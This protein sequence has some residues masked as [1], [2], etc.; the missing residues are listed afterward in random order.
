[1]EK[2][3]QVEIK[4][5]IMTGDSAGGALCMAITNWC[6]VNGIRGPDFI[7][8][9][10]PVANM[11]IKTWYTPSVMLAMDDAFLS[12]SMLKMCI[13]TY[14]PEDKREE[15]DSYIS[16]YAT[17]DWVL[18]RYPRVVMGLSEYD[19]MKDDAFRLASRLLNLRN[20]VKVYYNRFMPHGI[21]SL[22]VSDQVPEAQVWKEKT[23][24]LLV[25]YVNERREQLA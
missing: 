7:F 22:S 14:V 20:E 18:E 6:I 16:I 8:A 1:M 3:L 12:Y 23:N 10:Y 4:T 21:L 15:L 24:E 5:L 19:P 13:N 11:N 9:N 17:P 25:E 2:V